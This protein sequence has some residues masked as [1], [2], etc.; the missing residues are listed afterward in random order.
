MRHAEVLVKESVESDRRKPNA[1]EILLSA[2]QFYLRIESHSADL[3][4]SD[5]ENLRL[6]CAQCRTLVTELQEAYIEDRLTIESPTVRATYR[7][8]VLSLMWIG[9]HARQVIDYRTF[10]KLVMIESSFAYLLVTRP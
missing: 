9:F 2:E 4:P 10:R 8:L 1:W 3:D 7:F 6:Q 5:S